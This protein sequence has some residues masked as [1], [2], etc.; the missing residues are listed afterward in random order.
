VPFD[1]STITTLPALAAVLTAALVALA[2]A[3]A[4]VRR[5]ASGVELARGPLV[6]R[7]D[8]RLDVAGPVVL[9][10]EGPHRTR[11][12]A[13]LSFRLTDLVTGRRVPERRVWLRTTT[14]GAARVRLALMRFDLERPGVYRLDV[15]GLAPGSAA[16]APGTDDAVGALVETPPSGVGLPLA[17]V[18]TLAAGA[19]AIAALVGIGWL[20]LAAHAPSSPGASASSGAPPAPAQL[21]TAQLAPRAAS[22]A[23]GGRQ[24]AAPV[25]LGPDAADVHWTKGA[26]TLRVPASLAVRAA[27]DELDVRDPH[28]ASTYLVGHVVTF[29]PPTTAALLAGVAAESAAGRVTAGLLEGYT[30]ASFGGVDGVLTIES[31]GDGASRMAVWGGYQPTPTGVRN[32][33][34]IFGADAADFARQEGVAHAILRSARFD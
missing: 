27:G 26:L 5:S 20:G 9:H 12:F 32:V 23:H 10:G 6:A 24:L 3:V 29:P 4:A 16:R 19:T 14:A 2:L 7:Q 11:R 13:G 18:A 34:L 21:A 33:T 8:L 15:E 17:I 1:P 25:D 30:T 31:R 22:G 28:R